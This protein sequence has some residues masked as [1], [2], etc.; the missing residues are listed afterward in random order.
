MNR[1][2]PSVRES[3]PSDCMRS[4]VRGGCSAWGAV[5]DRLHMPLKLRGW[6]CAELRIELTDRVS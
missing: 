2:Q 6:C 4:H 3:G 1:K 5:V